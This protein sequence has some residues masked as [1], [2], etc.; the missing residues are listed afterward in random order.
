MT[1]ISYIY[2]KTV[3]PTDIIGTYTRE[4][5]PENSVNKY[6]DKNETVSIISRV[7]CSCIILVDY[8]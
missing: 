1:Y 6:T 2:Y 7:C 8:N 5:R 3:E 4:S